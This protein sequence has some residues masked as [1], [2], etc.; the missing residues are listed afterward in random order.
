MFDEGLILGSCRLS[1]IRSSELKECEEI[2]W[3]L[4]KEAE[5]PV[6]ERWFSMFLSHQRRDSQVV[7]GSHTM[8][9]SIDTWINNHVRSQTLRN[10]IFE[11]KKMWQAFGRLEDGRDFDMRKSGTADFLNLET[12]KGRQKYTDFFTNF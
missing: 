10:S 8:H 1:F 7:W 2:I 5:W 9:Y 12:V 4:F 3:K 11:G 6:S